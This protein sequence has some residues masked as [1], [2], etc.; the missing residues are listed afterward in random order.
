MAQV[1][2]KTPNQVT[3]DTTMGPSLVELLAR[4]DVTEAYCNDDGTGW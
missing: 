2:Q 1:L 3:L 4:K